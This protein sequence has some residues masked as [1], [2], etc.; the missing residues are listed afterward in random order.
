M[1]ADGRSLGI[2]I[3]GGPKIGKTTLADTAPGPKLILDAE[4]GSRFLRSRRIIWEPLSQ[5]VPVHDGN[6]DT[7]VVYVRDYATISR[8]Y[9]WL[10]VGQHPFRSVIIDSISE[11]QQRCIDAIAGADQMK[12]Q[13]WGELLRSISLLVRQLRDL[14]F[15]PTNP[16]A[17]VVLVAMG[18][19]VNGV[20]RPFMQGQI[21]T[22]LPYYFDAY[23]YLY[24]EQLADGSM[25]RRLLVSP[26]PQFEAGDRTGALPPVVDNP[27][28]EQM[29]NTIYGTPVA[30]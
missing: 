2:L 22:V 18:R 8:V 26:H 24:V 21:A 5:D 17:M 15:H 25:M 4:G 12:T 28:L 19:E 30:T 7:C 3:H 20:H 27:N 16:L 13:D 14:T 6:W 11:T 9:Q 29:L 10:A 1:S 23:G